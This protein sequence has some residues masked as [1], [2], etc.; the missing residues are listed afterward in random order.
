MGDVLQA[1]AGD[2]VHDGLAV[3]TLADGLHHVLGIGAEE[4]GQRIAVQRLVGVGVLVG[5]Q[6]A[7]AAVELLLG[8]E[9]VAGKPRCALL[10]LGLLALLH[11]LVEGAVLL[12]QKAVVAMGAPQEIGDEQTDEDGGDEDDA[13][14]R[15]RL[16]LTDDLLFLLLDFLQLLHVGLPLLL[17]Q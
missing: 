14:R 12:G 10:G 3:G 2:E 5:H 15:Q 13:M 11:L 4:L 7:E 8:G 16:A 17:A 9:V 1:V 6:R